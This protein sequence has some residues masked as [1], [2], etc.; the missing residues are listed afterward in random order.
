M[1]RGYSFRPR[2][3]SLAAAAL[4]CALFMSLGNWQSRRA[5]EK[6]E[7]AAALDRA[8]QAPALELPAG[9]VDAQ[10]LIHQHVAARGQYVAERSVLLDN[11]LRAGRPGYEV[12][13]PLRIGGSAWHVL[14]NRGWLPAPA[15]RDSVPALRTPAGDVRVE[16]IALE[17]IPH[18]LSAGVS[19]GRVRQNLGISEY[20]AETGLQLL[21]IVI[22]QRSAADDGLLR[23]WPRPDFGAER[24]QSYALQWYSFAALA[25]VLGIIFSF[26]RVAA[27]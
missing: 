16:G 8:A 23:E 14:V 10:K 21:P 6:R 17:H 24:N 7:L 25:I 26:R 12:V 5:T 22:E 20:A 1:L 4:G 13:T 19:S 27:P 15:S 2:L 3:W 9:P 18:A 11:K